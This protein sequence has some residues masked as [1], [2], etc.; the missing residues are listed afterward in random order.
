MIML[1]RQKLAQKLGAMRETLFLD[2]TEEQQ[3][4]LESWKR[5]INDPLLI[6]KIDSIDAPWLI[7]Y[8]Q[9]ALD[10]AV[11]IAV[12]QDPYSV[13]AVD[14]S[15]V[16]P[17]R[18]EGVSCFLVNI[19]VVHLMYGMQMPVLFSSEPTLFAGS[20][21]DDGEVAHSHDL[22]NCIRQDLELSAA[23]DACYVAQ[24]MAPNRTQLFLC[25][26]SLVFWHLES[27]GPYLRDR[28]LDSYIRSLQAL[29]Q[30]SLLN[31]GYISLP[32]SKELVNIIRLELCNFEPSACGAHKKVRH[33]V[34]TTV[35]RFFLS[36][37]TRSTV[38]KS[39]ATICSYYPEHLVPYF[40]YCDVGFEIAR[41]EIP[42]WI[43]HD[44]TL[45]YTVASI[46][47]DQVIKGYGYP[48]A[49]AEAHEQAVVKGPDREF[50]YLML[51]KMSVDHKRVRTISPK[52]AK[53]RVIGM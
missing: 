48:I 25:D 4:A 41:V 50:F 20:D 12:Y 2:T 38:F 39:T 15:Q 10:Y 31:A 26:G 28:F 33:I 23:V 49:L 43:A 13:V 1:N 9:G 8:W 30:K 32:K 45:V 53:K 46:I 42:A 6:T 40:F 16:Y 52:S 3:I 37:Y 7:P 18:H 47:I 35:A 51:S 21:A 22:V 11:P 34:D 5:L 29:Y 24:Q 44:E 19:G 17:D 14:G 36:R 27:K